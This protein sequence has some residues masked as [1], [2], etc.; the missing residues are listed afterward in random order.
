MI[1]LANLAKTVLLRLLVNYTSSFRLL[2]VHLAHL[3]KTALLRQLM[4]HLAH[5][6]KMFDIV[7]AV[8]PS[9]W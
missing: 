8:W 2:V 6:A 3:A 5:L 9:L 1:Y 7:L 4:N